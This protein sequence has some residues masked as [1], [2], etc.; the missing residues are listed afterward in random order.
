MI[1]IFKKEESR[2]MS[3]RRDTGKVLDDEE[4]EEWEKMEEEVGDLIPRAR[5][6]SFTMTP[7]HPS[8]SA[9]PATDKQGKKIK[10]EEEEEEEAKQVSKE[11]NPLS[12]SSTPLEEAATKTEGSDEKMTLKPSD[13]KIHME[14]K[15][16]GN[17]DGGNGVGGR[18]ATKIN[19]LGGGRVMVEVVMAKGKQFVVGAWKKPVWGAKI[20]SH[21]AVNS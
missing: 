16:G 5:R 1:T 3:E 13:E 14:A 6:T 20:G 21:T 10:E 18:N 2:R 4:E 12:S 9:H 11:G 19:N 8:T 7:L 17:G 15:N